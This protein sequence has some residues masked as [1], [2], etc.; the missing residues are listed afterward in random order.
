MTSSPSAPVL[1]HAPKLPQD[2]WLTALRAALAPRSV[3]TW[4][5]VEDS[6]AIETLISWRGVKE[7]LPHLPNLRTLVNLGAGIDHLVALDIPETI[8]VHRL[9]DAGMGAQMAEYALHWAIHFQRDF[10]RY[11]TMTRAGAWGDLTYR[12][13]GEVRCGVLGLGTLGT[14]VAERLRDAGFPVRGWSRSPRVVPG[15]VCLSGKETLE[16]FL[17]EAEIL[18]NL[19]PGTDETRGILNG[20]RLDVLSRGAVVI[21]LGRGSTLPLEDLLDRLDSGHLRAAVLDVT[22]PEPPPSGHPVWAH[23]RIFLTPH[24][25]AQTQ[26]GPAAAVVAALL[27]AKDRGEEGL[28]RVRDLARGY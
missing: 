15:V 9:V 27:S 23:P 25:S 20:A 22:D 7:V 1:F 17:A 14:Q 18:V 12:P 24:V 11:L 19:L 3:V 21:N 2:P 5:A 10:D 8:A 4:E 6:T 26:C 16:R 13:P 28:G